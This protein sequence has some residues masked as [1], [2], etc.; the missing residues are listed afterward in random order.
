MFRA[1][2]FNDRAA[3]LVVES[4]VWELCTSE[5]YG[6]ECRRYPPGRYADLGY[7]MS[8][9][10]SSARLVRSVE[11]APA[12]L[13]YGPPPP[14]PTQPA[15]IVLYEDLRLA[16]RS[17]AIA[18]NVVDAERL[19]LGEDGASSAY[20]ESGTWQACS[21][22]GFGGHCVQL[23]PGRYDNLAD[24]GLRRGLGSLRAIAPTPAAPPPPPP[25]R[26]AA[27]ADAVVLYSESDFAGENM[28]VGADIPELD[29]YRFRNRAARW[30]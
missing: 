29:R 15:R 17:V 14:P 5:S 1:S 23:A 27:R 30:W 24:I 3:S 25:A 21:R 7:G 11:D 8:S 19:G 22:P 18:A 13:A 28:A 10:V 9:Q 20:V 4:G 6:G 26:L 16:G 12:V 2:G